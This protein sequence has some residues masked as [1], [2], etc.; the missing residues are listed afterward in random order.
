M[1]R[2]KDWKTE[3]IKKYNDNKSKYNN[4][5]ISC[6]N[7]FGYIIQQISEETLMSSNGQQKST[8]ENLSEFNSDIN[9]FLNENKERILCMMAYSVSFDM[10]PYVASSQKRFTTI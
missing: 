7:K 9:N 4:A 8:K 5:Y 3:E 10:Q 6:L 1:R 2:S